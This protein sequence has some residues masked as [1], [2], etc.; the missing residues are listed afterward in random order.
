MRIPTVVGSSLAVAV[1]FGASLAPSTA[2]VLRVPGFRVP[3]F[4]QGIIPRTVTRAQVAKA[5]YPSVS[6][7]QAHK[8]ALKWEK[9]HGAP[10]FHPRKHAQV[11]SWLTDDAGYI[12]GLKGNK[13]VAALTDCSGAEGGMIDSKGNLVVACTNAGSVNI[14]KAGNTSGP[15]DTVLQEDSYSSS[16]SQSNEVIAYSA[17]AFEDSKG[18]IYA[19]NLYSYDCTTS[20]CTFI[21]GNIVEWKKGAA[22]G[23]YPSKVYTDPN[24]TY[25]GLFG[26]I[27]SSGEMAFDFNSL[28]CYSSS[29]FYESEVPE[30][31]TSPNGNTWTNSGVTLGFPGGLNYLSNG[32]LGVNDQ[33]CYECGNGSYTIYGASSFSGSPVFSGQFPQNYFDSCDPV[34]TNLN[35]SESEVYAGDAGCH[36]EATLTIPGDKGGDILSID[37]SEPISGIPTN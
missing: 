32:D 11:T 18:N 13:L 36:A 33:G 31:D 5:S 25:L 16:S 15:A 30:L 17:D 34:A 6:L 2:S 22:S 23:S 29:C 14:Y 7:P 19:T 4:Q 28:V 37:F 35:S 3:A 27:N 12:W 8:A 21:P 1:L 24:N 9:E 10:A 26:A 20:S